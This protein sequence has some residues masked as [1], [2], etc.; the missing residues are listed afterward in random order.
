MP[1]IIKPWTRKSP[2][3]KK[4]LSTLENLKNK[5]NIELVQVKLEEARRNLESEL[6]S[7]E[8][9]WDAATRTVKDFFKH[10][11]LIF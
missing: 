4:Y 1:W 9:I 8:S 7:S 10:R 3:T 11:G 6:E 5:Y 2:Q